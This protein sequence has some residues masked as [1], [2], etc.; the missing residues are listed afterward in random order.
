M[1]ETVCVCM[2]TYN[3]TGYLRE[4]LDSILAGLRPDDQV[5]IVDDAST[6]GTV[7]LLETYRDA[8]VTVYR[9]P[10]NLGYVKTFERA[11]SLADR[12][13]I[14]LSDQDDEWVPGRR[15][16]LVEALRDRSIAAGDLVLLPDDSP[17]S[18]PLTGRPWR[19]AP[20]PSG[21]SLANELRLLAGDAPYYG[22]A[23]AI[24]REASELILPFPGFLVESHDLWIATVG[25]TAR[26][27]AHVQ[28][29]VLRRRLH[30]ANASAPR[31]RGLRKALQ[32]R[33]MLLR[34]WREA[35]RRVAAAR[36]LSRGRSAP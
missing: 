15:D 14:F 11:L 1:T 13:V 17:L 35:S 20:L 31:P 16:L 34:A 27:L 28:S 21:G 6:D 10:K 8:R 3:G 29:P 24:R 7:A 9:N 23:M 2:A 5:V 19:L 12:D 32:S 4:Q 30:D 36:R 25:N 26:V 33:W 18:S 22:C